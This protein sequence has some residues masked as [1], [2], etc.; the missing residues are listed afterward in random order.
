MAELSSPDEVQPFAGR[1]FVHLADIDGDTVHAHGLVVCPLHLR[2]RDQVLAEIDRIFRE[3]VQADP[4]GWNYDDV[5]VGLTNGGFE[6]F[7][8][9]YWLEHHVL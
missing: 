7:C 3:V 1:L 2:D 4:E 8:P 9:A 5:I 6:H